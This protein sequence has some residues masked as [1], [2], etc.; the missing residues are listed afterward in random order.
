MF[1]FPP[2][3]AIL[4]LSIA[5]HSFAVL[6]Y[7]LSLPSLGLPPQW[8]LQFLALAGASLL[9][10]IIACASSGKRR[11]RAVIAA[12]F[13]CLILIG[14]PTPTAAGIEL[15]LGGPLI[16]EIASFLPSPEH[17]IAGPVVVALLTLLRRPELAWG[18]ATGHNAP[19][20]IILLGTVLAVILTLAILLRRASAK[21]GEAL[22]EIDRL[23]AAIDHI[24]DINASF[25]DAL[26]SM[27]T[28]SSVRE[29]RRITRE[30]HDIVGYTL[31]NQQMMIEASL[32]LS[33]S[34]SGRLR[35]L[36]LMARDGVAE[37]LQETRK[38]LYALRAMGEGG[39]EDLN[40][41]FK[42]AKN[43][44]KVTGVR[45]SV[46]LT[47]LRRSFDERTRLTLHRL[48]QE[49]LINSFRHGKAKSVSVHFWDE[50][51]WIAVT[52]HDDGTGSSG[53]TE[54][55]G[56]KGMRERVGSLGG[57]FFAG[58]AS[59]GFVVRARLPV[60]SWKAEAPV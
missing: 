54:G 11:S 21:H 8:T 56:L 36:L 38:T 52:I 20:D 18:R 48:I 57:E 59:D 43:F 22:H 58:N 26:T 50:G 10:S 2:E 24:V 12:Q 19:G 41:L 13:A 25:Q 45:V 46:K 17:L 51:D 29:R 15:L 33:G 31:T 35:E 39:P 16:L 55:I 32:L 5:C 14:S 37:G 6:V 47:N 7:F 4:G 42:M 3:L 30:I 44:E 40:L 27:E 60:E 9:F 53:I 23:D 49:S 28:E 34:D 1:R